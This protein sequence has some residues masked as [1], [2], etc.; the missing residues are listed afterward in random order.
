MKYKA[1]V[2]IVVDFETCEQI[3]NVEFKTFA[4]AAAYEKILNTSYVG[5]TAIFKKNKWIT[6]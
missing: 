3:E 5:E 1:L 4:E 2:Y 6:K